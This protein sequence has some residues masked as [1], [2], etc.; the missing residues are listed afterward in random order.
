MALA[1]ELFCEDAAHEEFGRAIVQ[2]CAVEEGVDVDVTVGTARFGIPRLKTELRARQAVLRRKGGVPDILIVLV[3]ANDVGVTARR[4]EV[5]GVID[6][7]LLPACVIGVPDPYVERW[8]LADPVAFAA[9][10][11]VEPDIGAAQGRHGWKLAL[12][13]ALASAGEVLTQGGVEFAPEIVG[14]MDLYRAG[15]NAPTLGALTAHLRASLR[16]LSI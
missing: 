5:E 2:R 9:Q 13:D 7:A 11:G 14:S 6:A 3:D 8:Y 4:H 1:I 12:A 15:Q 10:F 16:Q